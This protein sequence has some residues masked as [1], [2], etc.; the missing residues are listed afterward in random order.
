[1]ESS[2]SSIDNLVNKVHH[3][4]FLTSSLPDGCCKLIIADPPYYRTKGDFDFIWPSFAAYLDDVRLWAAECYRLLADNG[5][6]YW[7]GPAKK[8]AYSQ[9]ILDE[10][11]GS[12]ISCPVWE[13]LD[14]QT[15][16]GLDDYRIFAPV[17]ERLLMYSKDSLNLTDC[18]FLIRNYIR[19]EIIRA[20]GKVSFKDVNTA[21]GTATNGG[22]VAS[23]CLS[24]EKVE[25]A[26]IT[27]DMYQ[28]LQTWL[29]PEPAV[30]D[31][32]STKVYLSKNYEYLRSEYEQLRLEYENKRRPFNNV[33]RQTDV[34]K[35][36][37]ETV[38][39]GLYDHETQKPETLSRALVVS[40][41]RPGDLVFIPFAGSGTEC[42][43]AAKE[44]RPF[45]GYDIDINHVQTANKRAG[46]ICKNLSYFNYGYKT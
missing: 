37:Q 15:K 14:C 25:P 30:V 34:L 46:Y 27:A 24:L 3:G 11:F 35:F 40:S 36:S 41:S 9:I 12:P 13:K 23:A 32:P 22:G 20:K 17:T 2:L 31:V 5:T 7:Y 10:L 4:N 6:L 18:V 29:N 42:A 28:K 38:I 26:M 39:S 19:S 45:I 1:M 16:K 44:Q 21:L 33:L 8:I 43:M